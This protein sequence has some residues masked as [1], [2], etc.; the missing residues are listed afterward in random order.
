MHTHRE[1]HQGVIYIPQAHTPSTMVM[2]VVNN[3]ISGVYIGIISGAPQRVINASFVRAAA[4]NNVRI[5]K[6]LLEAGAQVYCMDG[7]A[8]RVAMSCSYKDIVDLI[9]GAKQNYV[10]GL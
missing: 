2:C 8:M 4:E 6:L 9:L 5:A 3:D 7:I 10:T 1:K